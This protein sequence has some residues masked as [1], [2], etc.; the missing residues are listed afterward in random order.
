MAKRPTTL[1]VW[2]CLGY[3]L[4]VVL[5]VGFLFAFGFWFG[6]HIAVH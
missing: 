4:A 5:F 6:P 3:A 2:T 1:E